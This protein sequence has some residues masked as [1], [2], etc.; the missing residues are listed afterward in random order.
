MAKWI[1]LLKPGAWKDRA[2]KAVEITKET[3]RR[4]H[5]NYNAENPAHILVGHPDTSKVPSFGV[6]DSLKIAGDVLLCKPGRVVAEFASLV[7]KG[8]FPG[9]SAGLTADC[10]RLDHVA[11]LSAERPAIDGLKPVLEFSAQPESSVVSVD[12]SGTFNKTEFS[13]A[14]EDWL[15]W[16]IKAVGRLLRNV[17]NYLIE[18]DGQERADKIMEEW[19]I[20]N[21]QDDP[22]EPVSQFSQSP[23]G[24]QMDF[25][26]L[27]NELKAAVDGVL[28]KFKTPGMTEFSAH[29]DGVVAENETLKAEKAALAGKVETF[30]AEKRALEF[31]AFVETLITGRKVKPDEKTAILAKLEQMHAVTPVEFSAAD[32]KKSPLDIYKEELEA[33]PVSVPKTG[34]EARGPEFSAASGSDGVEIA[35]KM[36]DYIDEMKAKGV[37]VDVFAA[38]KHVIGK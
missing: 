9:V 7:G 5:D 18:K 23:Q 27:Y 3:I 34:E 36:T 8:A 4:I 28:S 17:K 11:F 35:G 16:K 37:T 1:E 12:I 20:N 22:P 33:R 21:L 32:G 38:R 29:V 30:Q 10:S 19:E 24:G 31:S 6:I 26:K 2:G 25:E 14:I 15:K 13:A